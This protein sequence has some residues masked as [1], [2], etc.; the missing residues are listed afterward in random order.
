MFIDLGDEI[1]NCVIKQFK[2]HVF[3]GILRHHVENSL[4]IRTLIYIING[5][6]NGNKYTILIIA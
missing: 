4:F 6:Y 1:K 5:M 2:R 3:E